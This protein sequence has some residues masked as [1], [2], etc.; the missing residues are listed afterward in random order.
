MRVQSNAVLGKSRAGSGKLTSAA[1]L[2]LK[3]RYSFSIFCAAKFCRLSSSRLLR[4]FRTWS[5][6]RK[7]CQ[8][9]ITI[10][11]RRREGRRY[12]DPYRHHRLTVR[13]SDLLPGLDAP[14]ELLDHNGGPALLPPQLGQFL[15]DQ[16]QVPAPTAAPRA[17]DQLHRPAPPPR[18][19]IR[20]DHDQCH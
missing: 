15:L 17:L 4:S 13:L 2:P 19:L 10:N 3:P 20:H 6:S 16:R 12:I 9:S 18:G 14:P 8:P 7:L 1:S 5:T 11:T